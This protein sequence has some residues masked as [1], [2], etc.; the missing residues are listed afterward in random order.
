MSK[1]LVIK[2]AGLEGPGTIGE[3]FE[4][5][6]F[7]LQTIFAKKERLP[8]LDHSVVL[9]L[10]APESANDDLQYLKD[11]MSLI[12]TAVQ[13]KIPTLGICLGSQLIAKAFGANVYKGTKKE[14][15]F[16]HDVKIDPAARSRLFS[17]ISNPFTVFHWHG[18]TFDLPKNS[19]R[20][21]Y[22]EMY[23]QAFQYGSAVAVQF[24]FEVNKEIVTSWLDATQEDLDGIDPNEIRDQIDAN[25]GSVQTNMKIFY[26]NFKSVFNL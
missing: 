26:K 10:G 17:G 8:P 9:I 21:A 3:L 18:D 7:K 22:S 25:I 1:V 5:D 16:Y 23:N 12:R 11:E 15:G 24:H 4:S 19:T 20:L 14:I 2:N 6:G 13:K